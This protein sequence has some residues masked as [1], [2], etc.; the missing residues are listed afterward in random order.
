MTLSSIDLCPPRRPH[1]RSE[2][3]L[4]ACV[5]ALGIVAAVVGSIALISIAGDREPGKLGAISVY[6]FCLIAMFAAS[7]AYNI[8]Y[9]SRYR[10][11]FR[12][13]DHSAIFLLIAGTYTPFTIHLH[14]G[15]FS[16]A[17]TSAV[18]FAAL[19]GIALK[20]R[21]PFMFERFS[22]TIYLALGWAS[23]PVIMPV[24]GDIPGISLAAIAIGGALYS[25]GVVFHRWEGLTYHNAIWHV[26]VLVAACCHY[27]AV[28]T[29]V[30]LRPT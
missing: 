16:L 3:K 9:H 14:A 24:A 22:D 4:D 13:C 30:L 25:I 15:L 29:G 26:F 18:W 2:W 20:F 28:L 8:G 23:I 10:P 7:A 19:A 5:H 12:R 17:L 11:L 1:T 21:A 27:E 6:A